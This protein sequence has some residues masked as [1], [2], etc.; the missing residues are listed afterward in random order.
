M[1]LPALLLGL[2]A[3]DPALAQLDEW[4][5]V[6]V[7]QAEGWKGE[8]GFGWYRACVNI[9]A[10]WKGSRLLLMVDAISDV[11]EGFFNGNKIG[12]NGS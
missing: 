9:P 4:T 10:G 7:P 11:D 8:K 3:V 1:R 5:P 12:A 6:P 2:L